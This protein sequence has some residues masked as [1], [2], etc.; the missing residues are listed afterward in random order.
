MVQRKYPF[1]FGADESDSLANHRGQYIEFYH[2]PTGQAIQFKAFLTQYSDQYNSEWNDEDVF[3]RMDPIST[4]KGT[5]RIIS[6]GFDVIA[7][8]LKEAIQNLQ[9]CS[10][11]FALLY[12]TYE[13]TDQ[14][15]TINA[16][17]LFKL[18]FMNLIQ[19]VK[20]TGETAEDSGLLGKISGLTYEP[21]IE[22]GFFDPIGVVGSS[23]RSQGQEK[24]EIVDN[25]STP[26]EVNLLENRNLYPQM[27]NLNFEFTVLHQHA[28]GW[29]QGDTP[30]DEA[31]S[32]FPY[33]NNTVKRRVPSQPEQGVNNNS[34]HSKN[35]AKVRR[36]SEKILRR[37]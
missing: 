35:D 31:F 23:N 12:P 25:S 24:G 5:R 17:P 13:R 9:R 1:D 22:H 28:L 30:R 11:L 36:Q 27:I 34:S 4:F 10:N 7:G 26:V 29:E 3:G 19:D 20:R 32:R 15:A 6:L 8:S 16:G 18:K 37:R 14:V 2:V 33:S 21:N